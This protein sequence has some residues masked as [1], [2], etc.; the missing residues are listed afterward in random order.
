MNPGWPL[1]CLLRPMRNA[2]GPAALL[3]QC[4]PAGVLD[5]RFVPA[6][7]QFGADL[8]QVRSY[9]QFLSDLSGSAGIQCVEVLAPSLSRHAAN[10]VRRPAYTELWT[11]DPDRSGHF[12]AGWSTLTATAPES[13]TPI[14]LTDPRTARSVTM[15][16]PTTKSC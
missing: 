2:G 12:P 16:W 5:A 13:R 10:A 9:C 11:G 4:V 7:R 1:D 15:P 3:A 14:L 6:L 8:P